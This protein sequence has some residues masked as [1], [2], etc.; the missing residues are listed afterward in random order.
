VTRARDFEFAGTD[1]F[2]VISR[3]GAGGMGVVYEVFDRQ[4]KAR[5]A[6]KRLRTLN[7]ESL[8][9]FKEEFRAVQNV[10][11]PNLIHLGELI[12]D[13][14]QWYFT[15]ELIDGVNFVRYVRE[16]AET[17][18]QS[19]ADPPFSSGTLGLADTKKVTGRRLTGADLMAFSEKRLRGGLAQLIH[20][21]MALHRAQKVH[22][23]IKPSNILVDKVGRVVLLDYGFVADMVQEGHTTG[24]IVV[25][26]A[27]Y[28]A[29]EQAAGRQI[30]PA[31]DWYGVGVVLYRALTGRLPYTGSRL[32][33]LTRKQQVDPVPPK[34]IDPQ[35]PDDLNRM[36]LDLMC[37][38]PRRRTTGAQVLVR[39]G[40][41]DRIGPVERRESGTDAQI[42]VGRDVEM[43]QLREAFREVVAGSSAVVYVTGESGVGKSAL[44]EQ[45]GRSILSD[46]QFS[47]VLTGRC[48]ERES[49]PYKAIDAVVDALTRY[50]R[51]Q[52]GTDAATLLPLNV[53]LLA[54][55]FP[56]LRRVEAIAQAPPP[57][58][59]ALDP[60][61]LRRRV[62]AA[63]RELL[64]RLAERRDLVLI[65]DDLQW[66][67]ADSLTMLKEIM[68]PPEEPPLLLIASART[69]PTPEQ[70]RISRRTGIHA[71][72]AW[73]RMP[74]FVD[75]AH[76]DVR[77]MHLEGLPREQAHE[78]AAMLLEH[79]GQVRVPIDA[80]AIAEEAGGHPLFIDELIRH[81]STAEEAGAKLPRVEDALWARISRLDPVAL[82]ILEAVAIAG[83]PLAQEIVAVAA[84]VDFGIFSEKVSRMRGDKLMRTTGTRRGDDIEPYHGRVRE[85][86]LAHLSPQQ[87]QG[88]HTR[89][90]LALE[91]RG[92][93]DLEALAHHW[94]G[95][96]DRVRAANYAAD[97]ATRAADA[98]AFDRAARLYRQAL[99]WRPAEG[100][101]GRRLK[102]RL[103]DALANAGHGAEAAEAYLDAAEGSS[104]AAALELKRLA[105]DQLLRCGHVQEGLA[106]LQGVL[107]ASGIKLPASDRRAR[108]A[109]A[110]DRARIRLRGLTYRERDATQVS[111]EDLT[112]LDICWSVSIGLAN[113]D[114]MRGAAHQARYLR[115]ALEAGEPNRIVRALASKVI[116]VGAAGQP[117]YKTT[118]RLL[119]LADG[120]ASR[121]DSDYARGLVRLADGVAGVQAGRFSDGFDACEAADA[122]LRDHCINVWWERNSAQ[123][124]SHTAL[125]M[126]G[127]LAELARRVPR[128]LHEAE[129]RGDLYAATDLET[130]LP[131]LVWLA[132]DDPEEARHHADEAMRRWSRDGFHRQHAYDLLA[133]G[134][135]DLYLGNSRAVL[136]RLRERWPALDRSFLLRV[137]VIRILLL[138]LR[139]RA[140]VAAAH[141]GEAAA[142]HDAERDAARLARE[143][144]AWAVPLAA[145]VRAGVAAVRGQVEPTRRT[146]DEALAGL[147]RCEMGLYAA[148]ARLQLGDLVGGDEG[149]ALTVAAG[150]WMD[151]QGIADKERMT[152]ALVPGF[153]PQGRVEVVAR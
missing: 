21:V 8:L 100:A 66:A 70:P 28:M 22:R 34:T 59:E 106:A 88:C 53:G 62:F 107:G 26:T 74:R 50:M 130:G 145:L 30:G 117:G 140:A 103:G 71:A 133:Q 151:S 113:V 150:A 17:G 16:E 69:D 61:E 77:H 4:T 129:E 92:G 97:A 5:A 90:A 143:D 67:D 104:V 120:I 101:F 73:A 89:L 29:P 10:Q 148:A 52:S 78:L 54:Q 57:M 79:A 80:R 146:L 122:I 126:L 56:T 84:E 51:R 139:A 36:C 87:L 43:G 83:G 141:D 115:L 128:R 105:A 19:S 137:Q 7:A 27:D 24:G 72:A 123:V 55:I 39:L 33:V 138:H 12:E 125:A 85:A 38:D 127:E 86:I 81:A 76:A 3:L 135:I 149:R 132:A 93:A 41:A 153:D 1:R 23:D 65:I 142:L 102:T 82:Q 108:L 95:A 58:Q 98:L 68:Q 116:Y 15:M 109:L 44:L 64:G 131:N 11:H 42:F 25:G 119:A 112:Q 6:L 91:A 114:F 121:L 152:A 45:F 20:A 60:L 31:A 2:E 136:A 46:E 9:R 94:F 111:L 124:F 63:M 75:P 147:E 37:I 48:H 96:G 99:E 49:V 18:E 32:E 134:Q 144:A 110:W 40:H 47:V 35:V 14:G 13:Q 118:E